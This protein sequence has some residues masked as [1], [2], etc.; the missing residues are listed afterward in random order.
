MP[1]RNVANVYQNDMNTT[2]WAGNTSASVVSFEPSFTF[3]SGLLL[4]TF[5]SPLAAAIRMLQRGKME[6]WES[7]LL[8]VSIELKHHVHRIKFAEQWGYSSVPQVCCHLLS[9]KHS[10]NWLKSDPVFSPIPSSRR[11]ENR[12]ALKVPLYSNFKLLVGC[13]SKVK[14]LWTL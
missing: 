1:S 3:T 14:G 6:F 7:P 2:Q 10:S 12:E 13:N 8:M 11:T 4:P 9:C 5:C